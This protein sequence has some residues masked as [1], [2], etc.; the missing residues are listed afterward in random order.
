VFAVFECV[1]AV[2]AGGYASPAADALIRAVDEIVL[3]KQRLGIVT[4][5]A[6]QRTAFEENSRPDARTILNAESLYIE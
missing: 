1:Y 5:D 2:F 4:P 3:T 6:P